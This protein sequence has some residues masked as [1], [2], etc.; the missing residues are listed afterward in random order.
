MLSFIRLALVMVSV[1]S[2]KTLTKTAGKLDHEPPGDS[3]VSTSHF[4]VG[5]PDACR[6]P[7]P[8]LSCDLWGTNSGCQGCGAGAPP[9]PILISHL[10]F[11]FS[12]YLV[13]VFC[14]LNLVQVLFYVLK[15]QWKIQGTN[16]YPQASLI[17]ECD[18]KLTN[19]KNSNNKTKQKQR[20]S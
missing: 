11:V 5:E 17:L 19:I 15:I 8:A 4:A 16:S 20:T 9:T 1:H 13:I 14:T 3:L 10:H 6:L 18:R 2:S 7:N 12:C